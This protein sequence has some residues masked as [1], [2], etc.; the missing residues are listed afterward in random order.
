MLSPRKKKAVALK[1]TPKPFGALKPGSLSSGR[2]SGQPLKIT[3]K[4]FGALK[5]ECGRGP[6]WAASLCLKITPKPFGALK[7]GG[8]LAP[9]S[10]RL[11]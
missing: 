9:L 3:P 8:C 7:H 10:A 6:V 11:G 2:W 5:R 4:P 1:I